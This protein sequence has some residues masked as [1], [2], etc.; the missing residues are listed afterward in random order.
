MDQF[1]HFL[2][3]TVVVVGNLILLDI[4]YW[5]ILIERCR[6]QAKLFSCSWRK[7]VDASFVTSISYSFVS[8]YCRLA[9][10]TGI[11]AEYSLQNRF[12]LVL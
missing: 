9:F 3:R 12:N 4:E 1:I 10:L 5:E 8:F 7:L 6:N 2:V 11:Y